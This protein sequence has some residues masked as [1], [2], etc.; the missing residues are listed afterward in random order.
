[1]K[2]QGNTTK[3]ND[4]S[5]ETKLKFTGAYNLTDKEIKITVMKKLN[6]PQENSGRKFNK[7][8][9]KMNEHKYFAKEIDTLKKNQTEMWELKNSIN[10]IENAMKSSRKRA[11]HME[12]RISE[13]ED[14]NLEISQV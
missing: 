10:E 12:E 13:L 8:R 7:L 11:D 9:N 3:K 2:N 6:K 1:M 4:N 14:R 5:P